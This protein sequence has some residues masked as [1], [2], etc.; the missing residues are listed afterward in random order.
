MPL[1][2]SHP[3]FSVV[4]PTYN[5]L[6]ALP[7]AVESCRRSASKIE[8]IVVDDGSNDGTWN[9]LAGQPDII[10]IKQKHRGKCDAA[11]CGHALVTA[12]YLRFLDSDD[13]YIPTA[14]DAQLRIAKQHDADVVVG[15][16]E[17]YDA[18]GKLEKSLG[19]QIS[20][21]FIAQQLGESDSS[22][23]LAYLF[24]R[25]FI[26]GITHRPDFAFRD[27]R[28]FVLEV[29]LRSPEIAVYDGAVVRIHHHSGD[30][31]QFR[32]GMTDVVSNFQHLGVYKRVLEELAE[33]GELTPR[34]ASAAVR[35]LWPLAHWIA[36]SHLHDAT[37]VVDWIGR[38]VPSFEPPERG[39]L[40]WLYRHVGFRRTEQLLALRRAIRRQLRLNRR[41]S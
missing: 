18:N 3:D 30:R 29:A 33:R 19:W 4:I 11:N 10:A 22:T 14:L 5:R 23:Y 32:K 21:D 7:R 1:V 40:G 26:D 25:A 13:A 41:A 31:L 20:D 36:R 15:G 16:Y 2:T 38:L 6:W 9:W 39:M 8:L 35:I 28:L 34:R 27:D 17:L 12:E 37:C 24:R